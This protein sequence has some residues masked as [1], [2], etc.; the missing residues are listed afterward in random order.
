[1]RALLDPNFTEFI[2]KIGD[3]THMSEK[4]DLVN[5]TASMLIDR[6]MRVAQHPLVP[7]LAPPMLI[8]AH[9]END[10]LNALIEAV[11]PNIQL[12]SF[13]SGA[14]NRA[15]LTTKNVFVGEINDIMIGMFPGDVSFDETSNPNDQTQ[16]EDF[17]HSLTQ[18]GM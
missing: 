3:G 12:E 10:P 7:L 6:P 13:T 2:M 8:E 1:M 9:P 16:Y 14:L 4:D 18:N 17:L 5:I 15:I 11:C